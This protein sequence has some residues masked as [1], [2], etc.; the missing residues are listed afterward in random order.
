MV[1]FSIV[2][3]TYE[4]SPS[5]RRLLEAVADLDYPRDRFEVVVVDDGTEVPLGPVVAGFQERF[6]LRLL[7]Q[8][9]SGPAA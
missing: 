6:Q 2:I 8:R 9:N 1:D 5:L 3:P 4:R 7:R